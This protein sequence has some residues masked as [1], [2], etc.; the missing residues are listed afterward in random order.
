MAS[1]SPGSTLPDTP[2]RTWFRCKGTGSKDGHSGGS[3][4]QAWN[5]SSWH[6]HDTAK[7]ELYQTDQV[8]VWAMMQLPTKSQ[9]TTPLLAFLVQIPSC[10]RPGTESSDLQRLVPLLVL[11]QKTY[12]QGAPRWEE[13]VARFQL[14]FV[15]HV[16]KLQKEM[17]R[18]AR[19]HGWRGCTCKS[20]G[21]RCP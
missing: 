11:S 12:G 6:D 20:S 13:R 10:M 9:Q 4:C 5:S 16:L 19:G 18:S 1:T 7:R 21:A 14:H 2:C 15:L 8:L 17:R 3:S